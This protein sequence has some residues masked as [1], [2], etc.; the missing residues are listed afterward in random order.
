MKSKMKKALTNL[1]AEMEVKIKNSDMPDTG[2]L[3]ARGIL[4]DLD[5]KLDAIC[6]RQQ[7]IKVYTEH[8]CNAIADK[9]TDPMLLNAIS[10]YETTFFYEA[11]TACGCDVCE[12]ITLYDTLH[13]LNERNEIELIY[14]LL[15]TK[16][17]EAETH[18]PNF[19]D[20][21]RN[22]EELFGDF[23]CEFLADLEEIATEETHISFLEDE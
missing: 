4:I 15:K 17:I 9:E 10:A 11:L 12:I 18:F 23:M 5:R 20:E 13:N 1:M 21:I 14:C 19:F 22:N 3:Y 16:Y 8:L 6:R 7:I 2:I